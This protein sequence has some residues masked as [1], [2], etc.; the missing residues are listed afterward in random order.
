MVDCESLVM[1]EVEI[2]R[3]DWREKDVS[4]WRKAVLHTLEKRAFDSIVIA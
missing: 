2:S 4:E 1:V 3:N